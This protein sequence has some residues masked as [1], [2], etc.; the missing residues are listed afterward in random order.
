[1]VKELSRRQFLDEMVFFA[2]LPMFKN[3][4]F[5]R[6]PNQS[7]QQ[8]TPPWPIDKEGILNRIKELRFPKHA[9]LR[10]TLFFRK[11]FW[12]YIQAL[13]ISASEKWPGDSDESDWLKH[14]E[15]I[16]SLLKTLA[17]HGIKGGRLEIVPFE[18]TQDGT[19]YDWTAMD[20]AL[21]LMQKNGLAADLAVGPLNFPYDPG[22]RLPRKFE[23][24]VK[25]QTE[26]KGKQNIHISLQPDKNFSELST[27]LRDYSLQFI[28][29]VIAKYGNDQRVDKIY[30]G[31]EWPDANSIEGV[32]RDVT[33]TVGQDLIEEIIKII[34]STT[35]K[36][37]AI[38]TNIPPSELGQIK[39]KLGPLLELMGNRGALGL[40]PYPTQEEKDGTLKNRM[41]DYGKYVAAVREAFPLI[42][43]IFTEYQF[44]LFGDF[45]GAAWAKIMTEQPQTVDDF[46]TKDLPP[47]FDPYAIDSGIREMGVWGA[48]AW[49]VFA[50]LGYDFPLKTLSA[51]NEAME[52]S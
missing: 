48:P 5:L 28:K 45:G 42:E 10:T 19:T 20:T 29:E 6:S 16:D 15:I 12:E 14:P 8:E 18:V 35:E 3:F 47:S 40:D 31:N 30:V 21:D 32:S 9:E 33:M 23:D 43:I 36:R 26:G 27:A 22:V 24:E 17:E 1:M 38:N 44:E 2:I 39:K 41:K 52:K 46:Y 37:I 4:N 51:L 13:K 25:K 7:N 50:Q 11:M 49:P 34:L